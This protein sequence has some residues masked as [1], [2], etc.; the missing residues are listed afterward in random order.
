MMRRNVVGVYAVARREK[1]AHGVRH[2]LRSR[3]AIVVSIDIRIDAARLSVRIDDEV[4][5][6]RG[7]SLRIAH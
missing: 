5:Y 6:W 3:P 2:A 4:T 1:D 7:F